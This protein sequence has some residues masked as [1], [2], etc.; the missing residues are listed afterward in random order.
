MA[1]TILGGIPCSVPLSKV[2][3]SVPELQTGDRGLRM[4]SVTDCLHLAILLPCCFRWL[5]CPQTKPFQ[6]FPFSCAMTDHLILT[7]K[8]K[9]KKG[10]ILSKSGQQERLKR[11]LLKKLRLSYLYNIASLVYFTCKLPKHETYPFLNPS[12]KAQSGLNHNWTKNFHVIVF[13]F[14]WRWLHVKK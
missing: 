9:K 8:K 3:H 10:Q 11:G 7:G 1:S 12:T 13:I 5:A 2:K 4:A 14:W 6:Y